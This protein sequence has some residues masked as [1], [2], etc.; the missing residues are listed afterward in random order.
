[1]IGITGG[2]GSGK[3]TIAKALAERGFTVYD[4]DREAKRIIAENADVQKAIVELLGKEAFVNG[5]YNTAYVAKR[6]FA[7]PKLLE[8]LNAIVHPAV[9]KD[10]LLKKP[11]FVESAILYE[12]G[13]DTLCDKVVVVDAPEDIRIAR[14]I[15]RDYHGEATEENINKVRARMNAQTRHE[16]DLVVI[17]DGKT[18]IEELAAIITHWM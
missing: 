15:A 3:S 5:R 18:S 13:L 17:N 16:E 1:M 11:D 7:E 14:T 8:R 4:C 9:G 6:V 10:I 2:I 12:A